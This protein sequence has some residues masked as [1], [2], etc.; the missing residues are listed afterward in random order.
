MTDFTTHEQQE[1]DRPNAEG[2]QPVVFLQGLWLPA[3]SWDRWRALFEEQS[4]TT[5]AP[6]W[7]DDPE[8]VVQATDDPEVFANKRMKRVTN[9]Y[10]EAIRELKR[11]PAV[12][13]HSF[14]GLIA[15]QLADQGLSA[16][17][18]TIDAARVSRCAASAAL[19]AEVLRTSRV[20]CRN[21][22]PGGR[23]DL[24][25]VSLRLCQCHR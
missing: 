19:T 20:Q 16:V 22:P 11:K 9:H 10:A 4:Y 23:T 2:Q 5:L 3:S 21:L 7:P 18:V 13:G 17:T 25:V 8:T 14:G 12:I 24:R 15:Q 6:G 1:I